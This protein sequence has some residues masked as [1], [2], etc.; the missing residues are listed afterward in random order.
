M[1]FVSIFISIIFICLI[2]T[3]SFSFIVKV[4]KDEYASIWLKSIMIS[5]QITVF[6]GL[7]IVVS[8]AFK[9]RYDENIKHAYYHGVS[10][11]REVHFDNQNNIEKVDTIFYI[12]E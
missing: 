11:K 3:V 4:I 1:V 8:L 10:I 6:I 5:L 2:W 9:L 7:I 12:K